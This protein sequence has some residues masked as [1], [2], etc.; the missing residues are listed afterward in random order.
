MEEPLGQHCEGQPYALDTL[1]WRPVA[2]QVALLSLGIL[3]TSTVSGVSVENQIAWP[4]RN[5]LD[6]F[7]RLHRRW[8]A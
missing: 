3:C 1:L 5:L 8:T 6:P 2:G 7:S 4:G